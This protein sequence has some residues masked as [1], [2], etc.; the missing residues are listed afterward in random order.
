MKSG[1]G[2]EEVGEGRHERFNAMAGLQEMAI[3]SMHKRIGGT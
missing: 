2:C 3:W 1:I